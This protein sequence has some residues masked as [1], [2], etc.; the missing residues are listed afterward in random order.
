MFY[1]FV[2]TI[3]QHKQ[4]HNHSKQSAHSAAIEITKIP[5]N[6]SDFTNFLQ[7]ILESKYY[8]YPTIHGALLTHSLT[9]SLLLTHSY[10][11]TCLLTY[12]LTYSPTHLLKHSLTH[13][14]SLTL[15]YSLTH[16][17]TFL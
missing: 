4:D 14:Y 10:L 3:Q 2:N 15:T 9:H 8:H 1:S 5:H 12:L 13:P 17:L 7:S 11:L 16:S 6:F